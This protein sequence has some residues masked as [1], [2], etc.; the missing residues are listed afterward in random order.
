MM[1]LSLLASGASVP[2]MY[3]VGP[4]WAM[5]ITMLVFGA[6]FTTFCLLY[7]QPVNRARHRIASQLAGVSSAGAMAEEHQRLRSMKVVPTEQDRRMQ[8]TPMMLTLLIS[9][10]AGL[11]FCAW[12]IALRAS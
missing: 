12:G 5:W 9:G 7:D 11:A 1:W 10:A 3:G 6:A 8:M 4:G 2:L